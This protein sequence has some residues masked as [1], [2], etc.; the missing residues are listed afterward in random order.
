LIVDAA[1]NC[2]GNIHDSKSSLW[3]HM[4]DHISDLPDGFVVVCNPAFHC[5][6]P[7]AGKLVKLKE[8]KEGVV[9]SGYDQSLTNMQQSSQWE[10]ECCVMR[11][12]DCGHRY[13]QITF[14][15]AIFY[16]CTFQHTIFILTH[17]IK[18]RSEHTFV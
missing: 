10:M 18:I 9:F 7:M 16:G 6:G 13:Q 14:D 8:D 3:D 5:S 15:V 1:V 12:E 11:S 2:P 4:Y 17:V